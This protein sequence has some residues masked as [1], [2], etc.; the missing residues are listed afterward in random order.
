[1]TTVNL[2]KYDETNGIV[3]TPDIRNDGDTP[4]AYRLIAEPG[5]IL[6]NR[7]ELTYCIDTKTPDDW[8]EID[9]MTDKETAESSTK[10]QESMVSK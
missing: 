4:Y 6:K 8:E 2:Y 1:M 7:D 9:D 10:R 5:K 3:V